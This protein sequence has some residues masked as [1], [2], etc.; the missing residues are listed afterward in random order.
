MEDKT[1]PINTLQKYMIGLNK[2]PKRLEI[3]H[4]EQETCNPKI[5]VALSN[6]PSRELVLF[7]MLVN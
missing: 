3:M 6:K 2:S 1:C 5:L 7:L 4:Y